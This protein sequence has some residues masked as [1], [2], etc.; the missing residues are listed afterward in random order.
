MRPAPYHHEFK[1]TTEKPGTS[2]TSSGFTAQNGACADESPDF[3][4]QVA[5]ARRDALRH[6][7][8]AAMLLRSWMSDD[9]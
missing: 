5:Q 1:R 7:A 6:P 3:A 9:E 2:A 8:A 4:S